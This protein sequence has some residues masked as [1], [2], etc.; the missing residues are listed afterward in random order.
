MTYDGTDPDDDGVV[1]S[2]VDNQSTTT[3]TLDTQQVSIGPGFET[4]HPND[5]AQGIQDAIDRLPS[6]GG[7][8]QLLAGEYLITDETF[9][10]TIRVRDQ[11]FSKGFALVGQ[12]N[13]SVIK[14]DDNTTETD[15]GKRIL[16]IGEPD[17]GDPVAPQ[18]NV[19]LKDF[20][21][22]G[23]QD[24]QS[25][26]DGAFDGHNIMI[27]GSNVVVKNVTSINST[28]DGIETRRRTADDTVNVRIEGMTIR[29]CWEQSIHLNG[30]KDLYIT[31]CNTD[32][33]GGNTKD[34]LSMVD[35][36]L[37]LENV[38]IT[39]CDF[40]NGGT[41]G[42]LVTSTQSG[43][44]AIDVDIRDCVV[45]G[46]PESGIRILAGATFGNSTSQDVT[47]SDCRI[48]RNGVGVEVVDAVQ[49]EIKDNFIA[50]ND[51]NGVI[52]DNQP[53]ETVFVEDNTIL[54]NNEGDTN[55]SGIVINHR[56]GVI[57][58]VFVRDNDIISDGEASFAHERGIRL[59]EFS[60]G[61][62]EDFA[63][64]RNTIKGAN[65]PIQEVGLIPSYLREN[66]P[67]RAIDVTLLKAEKG[68]EAWNDG[69]SGSA[70]P[71]V[72]DGTNWV[73]YGPASGSSI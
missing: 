24:N 25:G 54:D 68:N 33:E 72:H 14:L 52:M 21:I 63:V 73:G 51:N 19:L 27:E 56:G 11:K 32:G 8:V 62:V 20:K 30:G 2:D 9:D 53:L 36:G 55:G 46:N 71:H 18:D 4:A 50:Y 44:P 10:A 66:T 61:T 16:D 26:W 42:I 29:N 65:T 58:D 31:N 34:E 70:G 47:V 7:T 38:T 45:E 48:I 40:R 28:G 6:D 35:N 12:G 3:E 49:T 1:E 57:R 13:A 41:N 23:N 43:E 59:A 67:T 37:G 5:G 60:S 64:E 17:P 15:R 22:D 39:E 69:T